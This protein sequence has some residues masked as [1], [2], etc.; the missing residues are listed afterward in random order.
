VETPALKLYQEVVLDAS[1]LLNKIAKNDIFS[2]DAKGKE[3]K[4]LI[5]GE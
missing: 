1:L 3:T 4:T 2:L 5:V